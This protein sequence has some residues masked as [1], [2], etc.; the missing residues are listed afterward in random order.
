MTSILTKLHSLE[1]EW[2]INSN[3]VS[4]TRNIE[5]FYEQVFFKIFWKDMNK[6]NPNWLQTKNKMQLF[7][8]WYALCK[9][10]S[11]ENFSSIQESLE[12]F[13]NNISLWKKSEE[14]Q[15]KLFFQI[16]KILFWWIYEELSEQDKEYEWW[17]FL[18]ILQNI[19]WKAELEKLKETEDFEIQE[20]KKKSKIKLNRVVEDNI[21]SNK[22]KVEYILGFSKLQTS[23]SQ[24]KFLYDN[25]LSYRRWIEKYYEKVKEKCFKDNSNISESEIEQ[26]MQLFNV[27]Y[28]LAKYK[29][30]DVKR[31]SWERYFEHLLSVVDL[32]LDN[33]ENPNFD[34]VMVAMLHDI[35]E[36]SD[37]DFKTLKHLF[38]TEI[39][40]SVKHLSKHSVEVY[41]TEGSEEVKL[42]LDWKKEGFLNSKWLISDDIKKRK[43]FWSL[44][45]EEKEKIKQYEEIHK[46][47]RKKRNSDYFSNFAEHTDLEKII[48][49]Y[50][51]LHNLQTLLWIWSDKVW[52]IFTK[53]EE[54]IKYFFPVIK[55]RFPKILEKFISEINRVINGLWNLEGEEQNRL[56][57]IKENL[58]K[59]SSVSEKVKEIVVWR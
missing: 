34:W 58:G 19:I 1:K 14:E 20:S 17:F 8:L 28:I 35:M 12:N 5:R 40:G 44:T 36:D 50:D 39:A 31:K 33:E 47:Y 22:Q 45:D 51:R 25:W 55:D 49:C 56:N 27:A 3:Y 54:T 57:K 52:S 42:F 7:L 26:K 13:I 53:I 4:P 10:K 11:W 29:F 18:D 30:Q 23:Q 41:L 16:M 21:F 37:V 24:A 43:K 15:E 48:K 9:S 46:K 38:W 32:Y 6:Q 2:K 59:Y